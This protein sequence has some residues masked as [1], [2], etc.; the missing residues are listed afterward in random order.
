MGR[1]YKLFI[2]ALLVIGAGLLTLIV[3]HRNNF[4][5]LNPEGTIAA[6]QRNLLVFAAGLS[7]VVVIPVFILVF[8][9]AW[10]YRANNTKATYMPDWSGSR[11][12]E[13][14]WWGIPL[15]LITILAVI[16]WQSS[17]ALDPYKPL[18]STKKPITI[19]VVALDWKWLFLYPEQRIATVNYIAFPE[20]T[21]VNLKI[22]SDAPMNSLWIPKLGGQ[23]Y[24]M[25]GMQTQLHL[26]ADKEGV[27]NGSSANISGEGFAGMTFK[28]RSSSASNFTE[29]VHDVQQSSKTLTDAE[30]TRL[31]KPSKNNPESFYASYESGLYDTIM[32]KY[33]MHG[34]AHNG[35]MSHEL[36]E[37]TSHETMRH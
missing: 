35:H 33:M 2:L 30:Y 24:A 1:K 18:A 20:K 12:L 17:H 13:F 31:A 4:A 9:I 7:L 36:A 34:G 3:M 23:V 29:W 10:K 6:Q 16:T 5:V 26:M 8:H 22:T 27:Y 11:K 21:P 28:A 15:V 32:M 37:G 19:Q 14:V 25:A